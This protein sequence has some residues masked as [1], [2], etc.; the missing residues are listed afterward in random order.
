[1]KMRILS[2]LMF[3]LAA[4]SLS[5]C[6]FGGFSPSESSGSS[7]QS[8]SSD[9]GTVISGV[10]S[11]GIFNKGKVRVYAVN[12]DGSETLLRSASIGAYGTY[13]AS[14]GSNKT[15]ANGSYSGVVLVKAS[16]SY[17]DEATGSELTIDDNYPLR[18][19]IA[20]LSGKSNVVVTPL[21]ELAARLAL[22]KQ[23]ANRQ[24]TA[25]DVTDANALVSEMFKVNIIGVKPVEPNTSSSGFGNAGTTQAQ[26]DYTL[27]LATISQMAKDGQG[28]LAG[29]LN[30]LGTDVADGVI[31]TENATAFQTAL[32]TYLGSDKNATGVRDVTSTNLV[33]VGGT[34]KV[35]RLATSEKTGSAAVIN[36]ITVTLH[37]PPGVTLRADFSVPEKKEKEPLQGTVV[38][39]GVGALA[40]SQLRAAYVPAAAATPA[41][42]T[43]TLI[44]AAG[45]TAGEFV[46][47]TCDV[48]A[49][50]SVKTTD[51]SIYRNADV[52]NDPR[53]F[54]A[55]DGNGAAFPSG[56]ISVEILP[57]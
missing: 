33:N 38:A 16:G 21:T 56:V 28:G 14:L 20:N 7:S 17:I 9:A 35:V 42:V 1:M 15:A 10:V 4:M 29:I 52:P 36:G 31:S 25:K 48:P 37:L 13:S 53:N 32:T 26:K 41:L 54:K 49:G 40:G 22:A 55:V 39:S 8:A 5:G 12:T 51:F 6:G 46:S 3:A 45:F 47:I 44:N 23:T 50:A 19:V 34:T 11:K 18:S 27:A 2:V 24:L 57:E 30:V 43:L